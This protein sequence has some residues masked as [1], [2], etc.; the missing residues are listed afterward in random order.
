MI[1]PPFCPI[2]RHNYRR[3]YLLLVQ[4]YL[5]K[6]L[7]LLKNKPLSDCWNW[8]IVWPHGSILLY[9]WPL[10]NGYG[11][12]MENKFLI[13]S[14]FFNRFKIIRWTISTDKRLSYFICF[15]VME[16]CIIVRNVRQFLHWS[17][18]PWTESSQGWLRIHGYWYIWCYLLSNKLRICSRQWSLIFNSCHPIAKRWLMK[19]FQTEPKGGLDHWYQL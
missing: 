8:P 3:I 4:H 18:I 2:Y 17:L 14:V 11:N 10:F 19:Q 13:L 5:E 12:Y 9:L 6:D 16:I 15:A 7:V 1:P